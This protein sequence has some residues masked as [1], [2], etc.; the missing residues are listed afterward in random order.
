MAT[1]F[2]RWTRQLARS[3]AYHKRHPASEEATRRSG[4]SFGQHGLTDQEWQ[5]REEKRKATRDYYWGIELDAE[6]QA[7]RGW[8]DYQPASASK[9]KGKSKMRSHKGKGAAEHFR[10]PRRVEEM[11][12]HEQWLV[13]YYKNGARQFLCLSE[14]IH[15]LHSDFV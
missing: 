9:G 8:R 6:D 12:T 2:A 1:H 11:W 14:P 7:A 10:G 3:V 15:M 4:H 13:Y 5:D